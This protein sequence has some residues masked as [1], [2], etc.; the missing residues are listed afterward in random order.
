M[1][2]SAKQ[3]TN[4]G[5]IIDNLDGRFIERKKNL[6]MDI[7][8]GK[9]SKEIVEYYSLKYNA[10]AKLFFYACV[11]L[12]IYLIIRYIE[13][14]GLLPSFI[15]TPFL[16]LLSTLGIIYYFYLR[17]DI[18]RRSNINFDKYKYKF[19]DKDRNT[20]PVAKYEN[21]NYSSCIGAD[22][23]SYGQTFDIKLNKCQM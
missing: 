14:I 19:N 7:D 11:I 4:Y 22:C 10:Y 8:N 17:Q 13:V 1:S 3:E 5:S 20:T 16:L 15:A 12:I 9:R 23:C 6:L 18:N 21:Q 2:L